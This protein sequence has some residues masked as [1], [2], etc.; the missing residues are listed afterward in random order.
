MFFTWACVSHEPGPGWPEP[1]RRGDL[2]LD[3]DCKNSPLHALADL[4]KLTC[5]FLPEKYGIDPW[6][7]RFF[8]S[9]SKGFHAE[10]PA[11]FFGLQNGHPELPLIY[12]RLVNGWVEELGLTTIDLSMYCM[13][14]GKMW[15]LPNVKRENGRYKVPL[16][17]DDFAY[18][19]IEY[20]WAMSEA[21]RTA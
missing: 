21:P 14:R 20:L 2:P 9:G 10:V 6:D 13:K 15:R 8:C 1:N 5:F 7:I 17:R 4:R 18:G 11:H 19:G 3:S 16:S 12:R